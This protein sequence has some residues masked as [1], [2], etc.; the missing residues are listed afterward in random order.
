MKKLT[1]LVLAAGL[2]VSSFAGSA[3]AAEFKPFAQFAEEFTYGD[4][5]AAVTGIDKKTGFHADGLGADE[6]FNAAT[7]IRFGFDY[8]A[9]EDLSATI[10]FQYG[11]HSWGDHNSADYKLMGTKYVRTVKFDDDPDADLRMRLAYID[12]TIPGT[13]AKVRMG[14]QAVVTPSYA[15]GS[16]M[17]DSRADA[18]SVM[19][20]VNEN[21]TLGAT[22][23]RLASDKGGYQN[24]DDADAIMLNAEF[25]FDGFKVAPWGMYAVKQYNAKRL[26]DNFGPLDHHANAYVLGLSAE[27]SMFDPFVFAVDTLYSNTDYSARTYPDSDNYDGFYVGGSA[28]YKLSNGTLALKGWYATGEEDKN[29]DRGFVYLDGGFSATTMLF[30]DNII[31]KDGYNTLHDDT[32]FGTWGVVAEY[33]G[34]SFMDKLTHTARVAYVTGTNELT[35]AESRV[36]TLDF[37]YLTEDDNLIEVDFNSTY[38]IYKNLSATLEL[39]YIFVDMGNLAQGVEEHDDVFRSA[40][41]FVYNF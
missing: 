14:R 40:L 34:F 20:N 21:I 4:A 39:G 7:R 38:E 29:N 5:G 19:G 30:G 2:V 31:G 6:N 16:A 17:L 11:T 24:V 8:V 35:E 32:P 41:T 13:E 9:S 12:W 27:L 25:A 10:L 26:N 15:F 3:S 28:A 18:V 22:W 23:M 36:R 1:T 37:G 33:A